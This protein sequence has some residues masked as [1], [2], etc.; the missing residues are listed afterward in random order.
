MRAIDK[1]LK[2]AFLVAFIRRLSSLTAENKKAI[3]C[4]S[5]S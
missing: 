2:K 5:D 4:R 3:D 1:Q